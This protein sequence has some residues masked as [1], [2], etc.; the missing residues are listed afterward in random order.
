LKRGN[1]ANRIGPGAAVYL[2]AVLEYLSAEVLELAGNAARQNRKG[3]ILPRHILLAVRNDEELTR[4]FSRVTIAQGGVRPNI[5][6][7]LLP[8]KTIGVAAPFRGRGG[9]Q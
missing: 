5:L 1:Y 6:S 7:Q 9:R 2:T 3:R 8:K 4:L